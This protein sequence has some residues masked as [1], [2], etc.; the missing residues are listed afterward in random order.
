MT[1]QEKQAWRNG[2]EDKQHGYKN[3]IQQC[4]KMAKEGNEM[5]AAYVN[6]YDNSGVG[7]D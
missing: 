3:A 1:E 5:A 2:V 7:E 6:G 4:R